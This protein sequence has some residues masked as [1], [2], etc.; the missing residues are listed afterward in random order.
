V[1]NNK[2]TMENFVEKFKTT[3]D[4][5]EIIPRQK[6]AKLLKFIDEEVS[7]KEKTEFMQKLNPAYEEARD[8]GDSGKLDKMYEEFIKRKKLKRLEKI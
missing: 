6:W 7:E 5:D 8:K 4:T 1:N 2:K 3:E